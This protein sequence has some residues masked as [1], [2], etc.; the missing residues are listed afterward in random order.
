MGQSHAL[1]YHRNP[2]FAIVG[3]TNRSPMTLPDELAAYP[4]LD[5]F[6]DRPRAEA[7]PRLD[8]HLHGQPRRPR[9]P[10]DG[11]GRPR[12]R[13]KAAR[14]HCGGGA[15]RRR[16][17]EGHGAQARH[18]L[19]PAPSPLLDRV[20]PPRPR[21][22]PAL[23]DAHEPQPAVLWLGLGDPQAADAVDL[24]RRRLRRSLSRRDVPDHRCAARPS[25]R[26]GRAGSPT[27]SLTTKSTSAISRSCS[28]TARSAGTRRAG[29]R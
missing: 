3:L 15:A 10:G 18:R 22:R 25:A 20:H 17:G 7:R 5:S 4:M 16:R 26:H 8:E 19:H 14:C 21:A 29:G 6:E 27:R 11:G 9:G 23:R 12:F 1:A 2:G 24:A 28:R 13:G